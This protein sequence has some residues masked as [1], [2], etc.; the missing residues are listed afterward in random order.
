MS[1]IIDNAKSAILLPPL[2]FLRNAP[3]VT[4][5]S[6][7]VEKNVLVT[8]PVSLYTRSDQQKMNW[9]GFLYIFLY[10]AKDGKKAGYMT[11]P[12]CFDCDN[13][14]EIYKKL[15]KE[16]E[17]LATAFG[18]SRMEY[19]GYQSITGELLEPLSVTKFGNVPDIDFLEFIKTKGFTQK[20][21]KPCY[22]VVSPE[23]GEESINVYTISDFSQRRREYLDVC[24][25]SDSFPQ[26]FDIEQVLTSSPGVVE[27]F[28]FRKDWVL[29]FKSGNGRGVLRWFPQSLFNRDGAKVARM[30]FVDA[31]PE[32]ACSG[33][34]ETLRRI[35]SS[36]VDRV[37]IADVPEGS[38]TEST[39]K[40]LGGSKVY[41]AVYMVKHY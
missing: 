3:F 39:L 5:F 15:F 27:H 22:E 8:Y 18:A 34:T 7:T 32:V 21:M 4:M 23:I 6:G 19:E 13:K 9:L 40:A 30:L 1:H 14:W 25:M 12:L 10:T 37:Q 36:G 20:E 16:V 24:R 35:L 33:V 17:E 38:L 29:F 41:E 26:L 11:Y 28:Y 31:S 2:T